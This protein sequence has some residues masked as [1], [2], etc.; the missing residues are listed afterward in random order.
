[1]L[2]LRPMVCCFAVVALLATHS[3]SEAQHKETRVFQIQINGRE[4]G[5][6]T[7]DIREENGTTYMKGN[8]DVKFKPILAP[9]YNLRMDTEEWWQEGR[10]ANMKTTTTENG[11]RTEVV[12]KAQ[13]DQ[14]LVHAN[15]QVRSVSWECWSNSFWKL[16]DK[17][18][19]NAKIQC[20]KPTPA[21]K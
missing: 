14:I 18:F 17:R 12:A 8:V 2:F 3:I 15:G 9:A 20:S 13:A 16:A 1:M 6:S 11:K 19:H 4:A 21:R 5:S 10:L 7:I